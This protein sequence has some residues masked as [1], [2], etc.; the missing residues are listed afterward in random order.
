LI[1]E[2][3]SEMKNRMGTLEEKVTNTTEEVTSRG[4]CAELIEGS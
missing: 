1:N 2:L 4:N 3:K